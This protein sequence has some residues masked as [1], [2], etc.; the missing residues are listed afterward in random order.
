[1]A[2][3]SDE[4]EPKTDEFTPA[5]E[6]LTLADSDALVAALVLAATEL[7]ADPCCDSTTLAAFEFAS[8]AEIDDDAEPPAATADD[9]NDDSALL[10]LA[11]LATDAL[12]D[13][14]AAAEADIEPDIEPAADAEALIDAAREALVAPLAVCDAACDASDDALNESAVDSLCDRETSPCSEET[15]AESAELATTELAVLALF[16]TLPATLADALAE[17]D[18]LPA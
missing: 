15:C 12:A 11:E 3:E 16:D 8:E 14:L 6:L 4:L 13:A 2:D 10:P 1:M 17:P 5:I 18:T 9:S 7:D